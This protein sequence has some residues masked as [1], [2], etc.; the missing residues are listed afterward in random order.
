M[1]GINFLF[2][3]KNCMMLMYNMPTRYDISNNLSRTNWDGEIF[4]Q[5]SMISESCAMTCGYSEFDN[6]DSKAVT[7]DKPYLNGT[8]NVQLTSD[9]NVN[10]WCS[11]VT[12]SGFTINVS[13]A[14]TGIV[15]WGA[16]GS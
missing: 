4:V 3:K 7:F 13:A 5:G 9:S 15:Y 8:Y 1:Y 11:N 16:R 2:G 10:V 14:F 6:E 12:A